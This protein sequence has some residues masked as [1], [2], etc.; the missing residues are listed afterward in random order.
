MK[1]PPHIRLGALAVA[2]L[3]F[4]TGAVAAES[5]ILCT[6]A[7]SPAATAPPLSLAPARVLADPDRAILGANAP[8]CA[9]PVLL[10]D[11]IDRM[12]AAEVARSRDSF[13]AAQAVRDLRALGQE[14]PD[15]VF[16]SR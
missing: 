14:P 10:V 15:F 1:N 16:T 12:I 6:P 2:A 11:Q 5:E 9:G 4:V 3:L 13:I 8:V 7:A